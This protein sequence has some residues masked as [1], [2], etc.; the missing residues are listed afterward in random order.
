M[1]GDPEKALKLLGVKGPEAAA[2]K[3]LI[4][5]YDNAKHPESKTI[6]LA[7]MEAVAKA[8]NLKEALAKLG[9]A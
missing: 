9:F 3:Q 1:P 8:N 7:K 4:I 2:L 6:L 5:D